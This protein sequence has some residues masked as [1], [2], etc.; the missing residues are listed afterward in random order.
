MA[1]SLLN[2][3]QDASVSP[4]APT[5]SATSVWMYRAGG[6]EKLFN[7]PADVPKGEGW[8]DSPALAVEA[9]KPVKRSNVPDKHPDSDAGA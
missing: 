7:S 2:G 3:P 1:N 9:P 8:V 5:Q 6:E 4:A